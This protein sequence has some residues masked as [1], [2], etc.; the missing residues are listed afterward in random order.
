MI[1]VVN[2]SISLSSPQ[3]IMENC[4]KK[5][6]SHKFSVKGE[7]IDISNG[8]LYV[9]GWGKSS[10]A[11]AEGVE[12][13]LGEEMI[14]TGIVVS[15]NVGHKLKKIKFMRGSHPFPSQDSMNAAKEIIALAKKLGENDYV[16]CLVSGGGSSLLCLPASG[17]SLD[18]KV[19]A[20][21]TMMLLGLNVQELNIVRKHISDIKGGKL[22]QCIFPAT[23]INLIISDDVDNNIYSIASGATVQDPT[24]FKEALSIIKKY[25]LEAKLPLSVVQH[26]ESHLEENEASKDLKFFSKIKTFIVF[27]NKSLLRCIK[28]VAM[29]EGFQNV[30]V[31]EKPFKEDINDAFSGF[32]SFVSET[33]NKYKGSGFLAIAGGEAEVKEEHK[34]KGGRAQHFAALMIPK[35]KEFKD[36][37]F[38]A[39]A[40]DGRDFIEGIAGALVNDKT[41]ETINKEKVDYNSYV[42]GTDSFNLHKILNTHLFSTKN[43]GINV[44]DVYIFA[45][46][47]E[48]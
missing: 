45:K 12:L 2:K 6:S 34:G 11:M 13:V 5:I 42:K 23:A 28:K 21:E 32:N 47:K 24:T 10:A 25:G 18:D 37:S 7:V 35:I 9:L 36:S 33:K 4:I 30:E 26:I 3:S 46:S 14:E 1:S 38:V 48:E 15:N 43:N 20:I 16:L 17:I 22:G 31:Y 29:E 27:D 40:S 8:K 39:I 19:K 41:I 44:F